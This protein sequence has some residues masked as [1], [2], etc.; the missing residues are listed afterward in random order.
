LHYAPSTDAVS[1][2]RCLALCL[3]SEA[4]WVSWN[5]WGE[6]PTHRVDVQLVDSETNRLW[7]EIEDTIHLIAKEEPMIA[8]DVKGTF[9][10]DHADRAGQFHLSC[11]RNQVWHSGIPG[12]KVAALSL[13]GELEVHAIHH[14][15][16]H[17][18]A[19]MMGRWMYCSLDPYV[20]VSG[21]FIEVSALV[22]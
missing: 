21:G 15:D 14:E 11:D 7:R 13:H 10:Q 16:V 6:R 9:V 5:V 2:W 8:S 20:L 3:R 18:L 17:Y 12:N 19:A 4:W 1:C 22:F